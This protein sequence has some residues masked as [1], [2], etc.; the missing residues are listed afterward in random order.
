MTP[1]ALAAQLDR[2]VLGLHHMRQFHQAPAALSAAPAAL[3]PKIT[4]Y[5]WMPQSI[6]K[7]YWA[8]SGYQVVFCRPD[9]TR[10]DNLSR[11]RTG[12]LEFYTGTVL[13]ERLSPGNDHTAE[14]PW[15]AGRFM[16]DGP[17]FIRVYP[18]DLDDIPWMIGSAD[19]QQLRKRQGL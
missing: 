4:F 6:K 9:A 8:A 18:I 11:A 5:T 13:P 10:Q 16:I 17:G 2:E 1:A 19:W 15:V 3:S 14:V 12:P 7:E